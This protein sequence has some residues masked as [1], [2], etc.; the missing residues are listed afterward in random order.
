[1]LCSDDNGFKPQRGESKFVAAWFVRLLGCCSNCALVLDNAQL[2]YFEVYNALFVL[3][4][5][6]QTGLIL[7]N[8]II[9]HPYANVHTNTP[10]KHL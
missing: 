2:P 7:M 9:V 3:Y 8:P 5:L 1:M 4:T 10:T 6:C